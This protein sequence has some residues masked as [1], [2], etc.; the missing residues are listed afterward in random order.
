MDMETYNTQVSDREAYT[1]T[2]LARAYRLSRATLY[3]LWREGVGPQRMRVHGRVLIS[4]EA[5]EK[6]R[7]RVEAASAEAA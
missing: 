4:R 6:W 2:E 5:A 7:Q 1:V 3:N